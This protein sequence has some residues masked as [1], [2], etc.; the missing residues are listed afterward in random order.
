V[1]I[2]WQ[3]ERNENGITATST[4]KRLGWVE[5]KVSL[6]ILEDPLRHVPVA[7]NWPAGTSEVATR[8]EQVGVPL[9]ATR[10]EARDQLK[11]KGQSAGR[12]R[13]LS[14]ALRWRRE[15]ARERAES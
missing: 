12:N 15:Q 13:V 6:S 2:V 8:L 14:A 9:L 3:L 4:F 11:E 7:Q 10:Q 5:D 1:D